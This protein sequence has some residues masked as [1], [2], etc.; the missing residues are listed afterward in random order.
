[1]R[2]IEFLK[3]GSVDKHYRVDYKTKL[4]ELSSVHREIHKKLL[5]QGYQYISSGIDQHVYSEPNTNNVLK[6]FGT[7]SGA[8]GEDFT[9]D[10][11]MFFTWVRYCMRH[12]N[13]PLF[14]KFYGYETFQYRGKNYLQ[15]RQEKLQTLD[16]DMCFLL[17]YLRTVANSETKYDQVK[18]YLF[19]KGD[20]VIEVYNDVIRTMGEKKFKLFYLT[21]VFLYKIAKQ[22][23]YGPDFHCGNVMQRK[24]RTPV[25]LDPWTV[26]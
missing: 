13:N 21:L 6:I 23:G 5:S 16:A 10:Q 14:P 26:P 22:K 8:S 18:D 4:N 25:F 24:D 11:K 12:S 9:P 15:I 20:S 3:E 2:A 7:G 1:M 19:S 17:K